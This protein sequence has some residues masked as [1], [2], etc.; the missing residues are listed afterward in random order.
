VFLKNNTYLALS[1]LPQLRHE[2]ELIGVIP[3]QLGQ[4]MNF[5]GVGAIIA[6]V[7]GITS[8]IWALPVGWP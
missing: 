3:P 1:G 4:Y 8:D 6:I 7:L 5:G 2:N